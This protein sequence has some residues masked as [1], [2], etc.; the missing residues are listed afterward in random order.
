MILEQ[1][2][3]DD[4]VPAHR[5]TRARQ[6]SDAKNRPQKPLPS[7]RPLVHFPTHEGTIFGFGFW[8]LVPRGTIRGGRETSLSL[9]L[10]TSENIATGTRAGQR[11]DAAGRDTN[12]LVRRFLEF[13]AC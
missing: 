9:P 12:V 13:F 4:S 2:F 10:G 8:G 3:R 7:A 1:E 11:R 5:S 6:H